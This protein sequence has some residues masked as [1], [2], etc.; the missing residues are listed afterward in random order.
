M[1]LFDPKKNQIASLQKA[2]EE[3]NRAISVYFD[4]IGKLYYASFKDMNTDV[5]KD[6]NS[7][8]ENISNLYVE[9]EECRL[10]ILYERGY[11]E[12]SNCKKENLLEHAYCSACGSKFPD[13]NDISVVTKVDP[14]FATVV[15]QKEEKLPQE[16]P[17]ADESAEKEDQEPETLPSSD[18]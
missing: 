11:K 6:I 3:K 5:A 9:I 1:A 4:E 14:A 13:S 8:C 16:N 17:A 12:C 10:K 2:I 15:A 18:E 7:R